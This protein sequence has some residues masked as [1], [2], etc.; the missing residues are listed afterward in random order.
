M[1]TKT[2]I[3]YWL[4]LSRSQFCIYGSLSDQNIL[5]NRRLILD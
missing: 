5:I 1:L 3:S 2:L 4:T